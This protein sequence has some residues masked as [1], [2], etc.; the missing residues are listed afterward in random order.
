MGSANAAVL[1]LPVCATPMT[2][3]PASTAGMV[4]RCTS[5]GVVMPSPAHTRSSHSDRPSWRKLLALS[6]STEVG[7]APLSL[8]APPAQ[9][10]TRTVKKQAIIAA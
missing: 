1:P 7:W 5:V 10:H 8:A 9:H 6:A 4:P 2:S 3:R